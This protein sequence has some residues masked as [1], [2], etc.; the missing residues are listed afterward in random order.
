LSRG[1]ELIYINIYAG[2]GY[3]SYLWGYLGLPGATSEY[4]NPGD[5]GYLCWLGLLGLRWGYLGLLLS[6]GIVGIMDI[7]AGWG[8]WGYLWG[9]LVLPLSTGILGIMDIYA[10]WGYWG[11]LWGYLGLRGATWGYL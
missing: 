7:Y 8:Y 5:H 6:T 11:Y 1:A 4:R 10:G 3:W 9:Y 2:W